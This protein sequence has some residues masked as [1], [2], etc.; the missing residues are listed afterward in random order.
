MKER[1]MNGRVLRREWYDLSH[2]TIIQLRDD[3]VLDQGQSKND[4]KQRSSETIG[5]LY[6]LSVGYKGKWEVKDDYKVIELKFD[7][8]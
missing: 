2:L 8:M 3:G 7:R 5:F 6:A 4:E 1:P